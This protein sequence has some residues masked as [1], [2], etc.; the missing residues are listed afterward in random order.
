MK[1]NLKILSLLALSLV[2]TGCPG[3]NDD[4]LDPTNPS[5]A[6]SATL[7][8]PENNKECTEGVI[9]S[10][11]KSVVTFQ[12]EEAVN[13]DSYEVSYRNLETGNSQTV[14]SNTNEAAIT[15]DRGA[16]YEWFVVSKKTGSDLSPKSATWRFYN[17]GPGVENY[18]PF[19]AVAVNPTRGQTVTSAGSLMLEWEGNDVDNDI[20]EYELL[21]GTDANP[22]SILGTTAQ[23]SIE[24]SVTSGQTYYWRV[25]TKDA[26]GSISQSEIFDFVVQ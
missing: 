2:F 22:V 18:A 25:F 11:L 24:V 6:G 13:T 9:Q 16:P 12:W 10:D 17:Q 5:E 21:F 20:E 15:L 1:T 8:F 26:Q 7:V 4:G 3:G 19:P 14:N 23:T